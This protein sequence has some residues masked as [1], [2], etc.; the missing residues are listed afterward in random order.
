MLCR[1]DEQYWSIAMIEAAAGVRGRLGPPPRPKWVLSGPIA[2]TA[3]DA[4]LH[5]QMPLTMGARASS[6][7]WSSTESTTSRCLSYKP[8]SPPSPHPH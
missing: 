8:L 6:M 1:C 4:D 7:V 5:E 2:M 3:M